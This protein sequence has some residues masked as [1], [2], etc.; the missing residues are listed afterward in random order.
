MENPLRPE[1]IHEKYLRLATT[2][3]TAAHA[4]QIADAVAR[5]EREKGVAALAGLLR[6]PKAPARTARRVARARGGRNTR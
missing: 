1:E 5:I 2:V 4:E 3:T 6:N